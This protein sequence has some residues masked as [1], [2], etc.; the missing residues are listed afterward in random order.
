[1][2]PFLQASVDIHADKAKTEVLELI[3]GF[4]ISQAIHVAA[5]LGIS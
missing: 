4:Q 5:S 3:L 1:M 2:R